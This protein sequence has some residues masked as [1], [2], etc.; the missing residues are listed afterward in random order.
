[1]IEYVLIGG[2]VITIGVIKQYRDHKKEM[3]R[4]KERFEKEKH[5]LR[6]DQRL[7][8]KAAKQKARTIKEMKERQQEKANQPDIMPIVKALTDIKNK[9]S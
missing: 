4:L 1:M 6:R 3:A 7:R 5:Y 2:F 9:E 8:L